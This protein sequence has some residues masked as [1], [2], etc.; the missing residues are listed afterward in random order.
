MYWPD[1]VADVPFV[2]WIMLPV[3]RG[4]RDVPCVYW[5]TIHM[6]QYTAHRTRCNSQQTETQEYNRESPHL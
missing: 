1:T 2:Y 3:Q 5:I 4:F 6:A